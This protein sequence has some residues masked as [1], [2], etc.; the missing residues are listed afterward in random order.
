MFQER[1]ELLQAEASPSSRELAALVSGSCACLCDV[2]QAGGST[3]Y[4][5]SDAKACAVPLHRYRHCKALGHSAY[6][7]VLLS[8]Y[9]LS[10]LAVDNLIP[11]RKVQHRAVLVLVEHAEHNALAPFHQ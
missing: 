7:A 11:Y 9:F 4:R 5:L 10:R 8:R 3:Y 6:P 1:D 2:K